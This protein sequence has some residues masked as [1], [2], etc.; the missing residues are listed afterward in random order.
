MSISIQPEVAMAFDDDIDIDLDQSIPGFR[1]CNDDDFSCNGNQVVSIF[2]DNELSSED[3]TIDLSMIQAL[4]CDG[5]P[6]CPFNVLN[7]GQQ[8][9]GFDSQ[10]DSFVDAD[11]EM[12]MRQTI[13]G[14]NQDNFIMEI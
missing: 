14:E 13:D 2:N 1:D 11:V 3:A 4:N 6:D 12:E 5:N 7:R 9:V 8:Y 10:N